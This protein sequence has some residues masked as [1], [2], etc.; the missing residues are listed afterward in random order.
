VEQ[1]S[2][3]RSELLARRARLDLARRGRDLLEEKRNQL[4][5][6]FRRAAELVL[7][8][9]DEVDRVA[10]EARMALVRA[11]VADGPEAVRSSALATRRRIEVA[12]RP[13]TV[14]GVRIAHIE[15]PAIG[16][17]RF[18]RGS[19]P[20]SGSPHLDRVSDRFEAQVELILRL[21]DF[22]VRLR[23]LSE[24]IGTTT[25][26]V[27]ALDTVVIPRLQQQIRIIHGRLE[28]AERQD[29]FRLKRFK[30]GRSARL[31]MAE[32]S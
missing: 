26:R 19:P 16:L 21:A 7:A 32:A 4:M 10:S 17:P 24:E 6:E 1:V 3:T 8:Q 5:E 25:R 12:A 30:E 9:S 23:R 13:V 14:T 2:A 22:E 18:E 28:E 29:R 20:T 31:A 15:Y 27:N 11:E